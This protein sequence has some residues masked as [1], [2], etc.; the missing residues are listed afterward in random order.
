MYSLSM[1][2]VGEEDG[3]QLH[4]NWNNTLMNVVMSCEI[5]LE[6]EPSYSGW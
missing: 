6:Q 3:F 1:Q 4:M 2:L 5:F